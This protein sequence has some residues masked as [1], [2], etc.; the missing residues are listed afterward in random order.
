M[1]SGFTANHV[2]HCRLISFADFLF[3]IAIGRLAV[4]S[5]ADFR[6][7]RSSVHPEM[8]TQYARQTLE[9]ALMAVVLLLMTSSSDALLTRTLMCIMPLD[10]NLH[11]L[12]LLSDKCG[13]R[14]SAMFPIIGCF[15][16]LA[17]RGILPFVSLV[18]SLTAFPQHVMDMNTKSIAVVIGC[19][20]IYTCHNAYVIVT[21]ITEVLAGRWKRH[22]AS[23]SE[24]GGFRA[25][26]ELALNRKLSPIDLHVNKLDLCDVMR[27]DPVSEKR[28]AAV[29]SGILAR[30]N[31]ADRWHHCSLATSPPANVTGERSLR[32]KNNNRHF[33]KQNFDGTTSTQ[34]Y[35]KRTKSFGNLSNLNK[36]LSLLDRI[37][38]ETESMESKS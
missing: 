14:K 26:N 19:A 27:K 11:N 16:S 38:E 35:H 34:K 18:A 24:A 36:T 2:T 32:L 9:H 22:V 7:I 23:S 20:I 4:S 29:Y 13:R 28:R 30:I 21:S 5:V 1:T 6:R 37:D 17:F 25:N 12:R 15:L 8:T 3:S 10:H 31:F 33:E